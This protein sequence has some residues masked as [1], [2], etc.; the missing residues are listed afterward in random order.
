MELIN[1]IGK[2]NAKMIRELFALQADS[3][4]VIFIDQ[5]A[6]NLITTNVADA[7]KDVFSQTVKDD[8]SVALHLI[9]A[10]HDLTF[11]GKDFNWFLKDDRLET[12]MKNVYKIKAEKTK[13]A[14]PAVNTADDVQYHVA[15]AYMQD[16]D[17]ETNDF[18]GYKQECITW[19]NQQIVKHA[20]ENGD[21][22]LLFCLDYDKEEKEWKTL[23]ELFENGQIDVK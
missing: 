18:A 22:T 21:V 17:V 8:K 11:S 20:N 6:D 9:Y 4:E 14:S 10:D 3:D 16:E 12:L 5:S 7:M 19:L 2:I 23:Q 1:G 13:S 15:I